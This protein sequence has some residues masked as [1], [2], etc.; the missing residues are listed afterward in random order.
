L[1]WQ[2]ELAEHSYS[3][4]Y[5]PGER[6]VGPDALTRICCSNRC[7]HR[8]IQIEIEFQLLS[9][10]IDEFRFYHSKKDC[11][12]CQKRIKTQF[13]CVISSY[14]LDQLHATCSGDSKGGPGGTMAPPYFWLPT[15]LAPPVFCLILRSSSLDRPIQQITFG[16]QYFTFM[17]APLLFPW[18]RSGS[19]IFFIL[20]SPLTTCLTKSHDWCCG[21]SIASLVSRYVGN[22]HI[23]VN[24]C[25][26][27]RTHPLAN[28]RAVLNK[29][30][31]RADKLCD[32]ES[33]RQKELDL[34]RST[35]K[36][37]GHPHRLLYCTKTGNKTKN[38]EHER[39]GLAI[40]TYLTVSS[41][42]SD[43]CEMSDLLLFLSVILLHRV[44]AWSL[45][46]TFLMCVV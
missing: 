25:I 42:I 33:E 12:D 21:W 15:P 36:Q 17:L 4:R 2:F 24:T 43:L 32:Q 19:P 16:Q 38:E 27:A 41:E 28:K 11:T 14:S 46:I 45:A 3:T 39:R 44:K 29:L 9:F 10:Q 35:L 5:R 40:R 7:K 18:P 20:E 22:Q 23:L 8:R 30:L 34:V 37:N 13:N 6:N 26:F 1:C 31:Q